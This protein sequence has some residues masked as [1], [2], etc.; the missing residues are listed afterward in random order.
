MRIALG[1]IQNFADQSSLL[2]YCA[3]NPSEEAGYA[4]IG[5]SS[6]QTLP[7]QRWPYIF[8]GQTVFV[9]TANQLAS[10]SSPSLF[11][12]PIWVISLAGAALFYFMRR[13][14]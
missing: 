9:G 14:A 1:D 11:G 5:Q 10:L 2:A 3:S 12:I 6:P 7:C 4:P 8:G 13:R